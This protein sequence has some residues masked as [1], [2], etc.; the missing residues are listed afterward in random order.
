MKHH[1]VEAVY[2]TLQGVLE[3]EACISGVRF[4]SMFSD[5][6]NTPRQDV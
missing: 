5:V 4:C 6:Q 1:F 2:D 3:K